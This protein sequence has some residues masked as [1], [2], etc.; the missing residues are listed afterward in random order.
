[1]K[2]YALV[3]DGLVQSTFYSELEPDAYP[4]IS[5][6]LQEVSDE[7]QSNHVFDGSKFIVPE[8]VKVEEMEPS[9]LRKV[10]DFFKS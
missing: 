7:V 5:E 1:M 9:L 6:Y 8:M 3:K 4:D 2:K 10:I